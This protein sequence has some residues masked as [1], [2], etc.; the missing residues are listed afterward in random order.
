MFQLKKWPL[1][2]EYSLVHRNY[3]LPQQTIFP[4]WQPHY[5]IEEY[6][7]ELCC[8]R[9]SISMT[10]DLSAVGVAFIVSLSTKTYPSRARPKKICWKRYVL[11]ERSQD[12]AQSDRSQDI[13]QTENDGHAYGEPR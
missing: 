5:W 12:I 1:Q 8:L 2:Q 10:I 6:F 3:L 4:V 11:E 7:V 13:I 9:V